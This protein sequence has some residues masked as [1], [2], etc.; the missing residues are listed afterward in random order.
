MDYLYFPESH[1]DP[2]VL[3]LIDVEEIAFE[4]TKTYPKLANNISIKL[5]S[6]FTIG[7]FKCF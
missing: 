7:K 2:E 6:N 4:A 3:L 1:N 5:D